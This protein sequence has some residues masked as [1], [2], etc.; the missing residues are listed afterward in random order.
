MSHILIATAAV[1]SF[2]AVFAILLY[3]NRRDDVPRR[4]RLLRWVIHP[5]RR[6]AEQA[7]LGQAPIKDRLRSPP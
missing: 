3:A 7:M 5:I 2:D 6:C 1:I 4:A